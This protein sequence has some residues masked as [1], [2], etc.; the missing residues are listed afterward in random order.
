MNAFRFV[1]LLAALCLIPALGGCSTPRIEL[2]VASLP[3]V[4][5]DHSGRPSPIIV[6]MYE[7]RGDLSFKQSDFQ[8][9]FHEPVQTLGAD[10]IAADELLFVPGEA[11]RVAYEPM[12]ETRFVGIVG[13][14]RQL[15]RAQWRAVAAVDPEKKNF[16]PLEL[17]DVSLIL[18][19]AD[20]E[21]KP[22]DKVRSFQARTQ[23]PSPTQSQTAG[24]EKTVAGQEG[25]ATKSGVEPTGAKTENEA[26]PQ[27]QGYVMP[28]ARRAQ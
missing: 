8:S 6:K 5:P 23:E 16:V 25:P 12:P 13:G 20:D 2:A 22:E 18:V 10:L 21:W 24:Q 3:N 28:K 11:R 15:E 27:Q 4:N 19:P 26:Q 17:N 9:L 7:L 14:F 1:P